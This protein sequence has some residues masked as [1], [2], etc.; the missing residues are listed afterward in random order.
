MLDPVGNDDNA[1]RINGLITHR[2]TLPQ[3]GSP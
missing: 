3:A 1:F 2:G